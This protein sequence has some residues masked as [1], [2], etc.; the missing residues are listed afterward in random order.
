MKREP[1]ALAINER[2]RRGVTHAHNVVK[3]GNIRL[4]EHP[5]QNKKKEVHEVSH[6]G[7]ACGGREKERLKLAANSRNMR[8]SKREK[9]KKIPAG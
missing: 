5:L 1:P 6:L 4:S 3:Q 8:S 2:K 7:P 9:E